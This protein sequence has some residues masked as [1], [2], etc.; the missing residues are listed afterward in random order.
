MDLKSPL[1]FLKFYFG[2][3]TSEVSQACNRRSQGIPMKVFLS[4]FVFLLLSGDMFADELHSGDRPLMTYGRISVFD[5]V[6]AKATGSLSGD[7]FQGKLNLV[8][9]VDGN[10]CGK[11]KN[12]FGQ[13]VTESREFITVNLF[14]GGPITTRIEE[15]EESS[16]PI[17]VPM[18]VD[19]ELKKK[20]ER[21][22]DINGNFVTVRDVNGTLVATLE[23]GIVKD[24]ESILTE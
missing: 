10:L 16:H 6:S 17:K 11:N 7:T 14:A 5:V 9:L 23:S 24:K 20:K 21:T 18:V 8:V 15:C 19:F 1:E 12:S 13:Y 22:F 2:F 4:L 3:G